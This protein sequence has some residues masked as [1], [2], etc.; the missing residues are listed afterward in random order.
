M[1][2]SNFCDNKK[3]KFFKSMEWP[4]WNMECTPPSNYTINKKKKKKKK[5]EE[6]EGRATETSNSI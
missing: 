6:E 1:T 4:L 2:V 5:K 3:F